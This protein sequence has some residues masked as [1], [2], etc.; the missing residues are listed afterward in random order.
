VAAAPDIPTVDEAGLPGL[1][2]SVWNAFWAPKGTPPAAIAKLNEAA[3]A[4]LRDPMVR[5][6]V[7]EMGLDMPPAD[8][9]TP[10]ALGAYQKSEIA[11]WWPIIKAEGIKV[12]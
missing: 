3:D 8:Q 6:R 7:T 11:K 2:A 1:Y 4:A 5:Q 12:E 9:A 10:E